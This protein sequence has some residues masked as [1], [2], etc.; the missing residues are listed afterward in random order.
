MGA[1]DTVPHMT[2]ML[3]NATATWRGRG[4]CFG[5]LLGGPFNQGNSPLRCDDISRFGSQKKR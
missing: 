1:A 5:L 3:K 2:P 4:V